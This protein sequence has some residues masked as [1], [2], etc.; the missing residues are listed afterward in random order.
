LGGASLEIIT[1]AVSGNRS[2]PP[3]V[4]LRETATGE[5]FTLPLTLHSEASGAGFVIGRITLDLAPGSYELLG[6]SARLPVRGTMVRV[7]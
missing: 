1:G 5:S 4:V 2:P 6:G 3:A 7:R